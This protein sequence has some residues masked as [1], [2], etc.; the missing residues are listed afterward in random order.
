[1][2]KTIAKGYRINLASQVK[3]LGNPEHL[4][5]FVSFPITGGVGIVA[6]ENYK[7]QEVYGMHDVADMCQFEIPAD[8]AQERG[9]AEEDKI[10]V[11]VRNG[12]I[13]LK[14]MT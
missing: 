1:M 4:E 3:L 5:T 11:V 10:S 7:G 8:L 6:I 2:I 13:T 12:E 9:F 14:K